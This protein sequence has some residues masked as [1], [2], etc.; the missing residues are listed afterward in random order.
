M[1]DQ[2]ASEY[3]AAGEAQE[4]SGWAVGFILF[5]GVVMVTAGIFQAFDGLVALF[6]DEFFVATRN[7]FF[8][9]DIT[10]WGWIHLLMGVL[11]ILAGF[12][13]IAGQTWARVVGITMAVLSA[14]ANFAFIPYYPFWALTIIALDVFVIWALAAHG[15]DVKV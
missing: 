5:A 14:L 2:A 7:Y 13:V 6:N 12:G 8:R 10:A 1:T 15:R 9:F 4:T 3:R 11:V